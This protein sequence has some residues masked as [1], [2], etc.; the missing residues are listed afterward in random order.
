MSEG[1]GGSTAK[2]QAAEM[3]AGNVWALAAMQDQAGDV[4]QGNDR[5]LAEVPQAAE[6]VPARDH[7]PLAGL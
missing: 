1:H 2:L 7:G 5:N 3:S 6:D 4:S